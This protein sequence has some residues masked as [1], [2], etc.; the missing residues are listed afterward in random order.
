MTWASQVAL[1]VLEDNV[2]VTAES[3]ALRDGLIVEARDAGNTW[4]EVAGAAGLTE[5]ATRSAYA[6]AKGELS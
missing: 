1:E 5:V 2:R 4:R 3:A 6:R